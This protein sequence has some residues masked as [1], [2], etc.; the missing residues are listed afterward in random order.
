MIRIKNRGYNEMFSIE[1][2]R[3]VMISMPSWTIPVPRRIRFQGKR[4]TF[5]K[6]RECPYDLSTFVFRITFLTVTTVTLLDIFNPCS[7]L[8]HD[9]EIIVQS[10]P[11]EF[12]EK[13]FT[14]CLFLRWLRSPLTLYLIFRMLSLMEYL[15]NRIRFVM[16]RLHR[17]SYWLQ[18]FLVVS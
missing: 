11:N 10:F 5:K 8:P 7:N 16:L 1:L 4:Y 6:Q 9:I 18:F 14:I 2:K 17:S 15:S 3:V 12:E 13:C